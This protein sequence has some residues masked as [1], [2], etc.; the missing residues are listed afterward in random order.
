MSKVSSK[1]VKSRSVKKEVEITEPVP[2]SEPVVE[3]PVS[4]PVVEVP[5]SE[6][7]VDNE[8]SLKQ[9]FEKLIEAKQLLLNTFTA[10]VKQEI[11]DLKKMQK[12]HDSLL[13]EALKHK[14]KKAPKDENAKQKKPSGFHAPVI[15]SDEMYKFLDQFGIK[16]G[17]PVARTAITGY[18]SQYI[19]QKD[20]QNKDHKR[21]II[22]DPTLLKLFGNSPPL[23]LRDPKNPDSEKIY[24]YLGYQKYLSSH[25]PPKKVKP[26]EA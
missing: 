21:E 6:P 8:E 2:V 18:I 3:V 23:D 13:K 7:V 10:S 19:K 24:C 11:Q 25:F 9:K 4:E 5:V 20:L 14:K 17:E 12:T 15:V 22:P 16:Q 1:T 26:V